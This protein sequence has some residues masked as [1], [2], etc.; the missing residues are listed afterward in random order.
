VSRRWAIFC[1]AIALLCFNFAL[2]AQAAFC[3]TY[4]GKSICILQIKRSAKNYWE[5]RASVSVDGVVLP[6]EIYDCRRRKKITQ[7]GR[8]IPFERRGV[9]ELICDVTHRR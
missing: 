6:V 4:G 9:G 3:R 7:K 1:A 8:A 5:Y 2:P